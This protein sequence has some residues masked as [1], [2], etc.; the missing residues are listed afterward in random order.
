M[1]KNVEID[2]KYNVLFG[3]LLEAYG[4]SAE[5][6][7]KARHANNDNWEEQKLVWIPRFLKEHPNGSAAPA[8]Q[9]IKKTIEAGRIYQTI[10]K[11][12]AVEEIYDAIVYL[13][14]TAELML[15]DISTTSTPPPP[16]APPGKRIIKEDII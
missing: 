13:C 15:E 5:S 9:A 4:R 16:P 3:H 12:R 1:E 2:K 6:K 7:G 8:Y 11:T 10:N 14:A